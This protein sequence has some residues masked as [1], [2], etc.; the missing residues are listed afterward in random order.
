MVEVLTL[1]NLDKPR[2]PDG[3]TRGEVIAY[4]SRIAPIL[5]PTVPPRAGGSCTSVVH[6]GIG[7]RFRLP[8]WGIRTS[9]RF[10]RSRR[11]PAGCSCPLR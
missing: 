9:E 7:G 1:S 8:G 6:D 4:D 10:S 11:H 5:L 2:F 3:T